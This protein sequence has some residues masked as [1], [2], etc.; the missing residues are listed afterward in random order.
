MSAPI[1]P[2]PLLL[3]LCSGLLPPLYPWVLASPIAPSPLWVLDVSPFPGFFSAVNKHAGDNLQPKSSQLSI[4][5]NDLSLIVIIFFTF[6]ISLKPLRAGILN[7]TKID[8]TKVNSSEYFSVLTLFGISASADSP[9]SWFLQPHFLVTILWCG[10]SIF[11][12]PV[13]CTPWHV[14]ISYSWLCLF[15]LLLVYFLL[16]LHTLSAWAQQALGLFTTL[17]LIFLNPY[18]PTLSLSSSPTHPLEC[19]TGT[20]NSPHPK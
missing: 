15:W 10:Y 18:F 1:P 16:S 12:V 2:S 9:R 7:S 4:I 8:F 11:S 17:S 5:L 20:S 6:R 3:H 19:S 13:L 14:G